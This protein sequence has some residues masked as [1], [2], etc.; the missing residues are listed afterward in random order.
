M[1]KGNKFARYFSDE[2]EQIQPADGCNG[3]VAC[4]TIIGV[5]AL[6]KRQFVPCPH[7][8]YQI[9]E[10]RP[11]LA[12]GCGIH[13]TKPEEC[14]RYK[15]LWRAGCMLP[16]PQ[17]RPDRLGVIIDL[18]PADLIEHIG[19]PFVQVHECWPDA[20]RDPR[21]RYV[22][23]ALAEKMPYVLIHYGK[24]G[25]N[26]VGPPRFKMSVARAW[27][28]EENFRLLQIGIDPR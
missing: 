1:P 18:A 20:R 25:V 28:G 17:N 5:R 15:C 2:A 26:I 24:T 14:S 21:V 23:A 22:L 27:M 8:L 3:C 7:Q 11:D 10:S 6:N 16:L 12:G 13:E 19:R 4:C 9:G